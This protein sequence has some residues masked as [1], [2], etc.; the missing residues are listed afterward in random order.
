MKTAFKLL[1]S[2]TVRWSLQVSQEKWLISA[3]APY[4]CNILNRKSVVPLEV[5][6]DESGDLGFTRE[7]TKFF[8]VSFLYIRNTPPFRD[9]VRWLYLKLRKRHR[10]FIDELHFS[11]SNDTVRRKVLQLICKTDECNFGII[12]VDKDR[13]HYNSS[14]YQDPHGIFR[15]VIVNNVMNTMIPKLEYREN[16]SIILD[17]R[18]PSAQR[19]LF[20]DYAELKGY[21]ISKKEGKKDIFYRYRLTVSHRNSKKDPCL[22]AA[23]FLAGAEFQRFERQDYRYHNIIDS[24]MNEFFSWPP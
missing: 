22:Q 21:Y 8:V 4:R 18:I 23:D 7:A 6:I 19:V 14:F 2:L 24:K 1:Y 3:R 16:L 12:V 20:K 15:Y 11:E 5:F 17:R 13:I 9:E 10:Y